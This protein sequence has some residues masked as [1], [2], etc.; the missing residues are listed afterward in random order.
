MTRRLGLRPWSHSDA[1]AAL[2]IFGDK[3]VSRWLTP[4]LAHIGNRDD[5]LAVLESWISEHSSACGLPLGRWAIEHGQTGAV[6]GAVSLLHLPSAPTDLEIGWQIAPAHW[7]QGY[8]AEAGHAV[9]HRAFANG[10]TEV[11]AVVRAGNHR[12]IATAR[13][14]G[15]EWVGETTKYYG[16]TLQVY[17]VTKADL[18]FP[19][20]LTNAGQS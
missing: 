11:F 9:A 5:M 18:D 10:A 3:R 12:G 17:R 13:R 4:A 8:G 2:Q 6:V 7:G 15:M 1:D 14:V 16:M 20:P 19:T